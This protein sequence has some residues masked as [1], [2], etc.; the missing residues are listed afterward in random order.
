MTD[1]IHF[2]NEKMKIITESGI[3]FAIWHEKSTKEDM[4]IMDKNYMENQLH[5]YLGNQCG[6]YFTEYVFDDSEQDNSGYYIITVNW[7][8]D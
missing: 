6:K 3:L 1:T 2:E 5:L 7:K 8:H 4:S